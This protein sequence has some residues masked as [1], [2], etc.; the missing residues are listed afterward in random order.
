MAPQKRF[1]SAYTKT[2]KGK[3]IRKRPYYPKTVRGHRHST[4]GKIFPLLHVD[5]PSKLHQIHKYFKQGPGVVLVIFVAD[6][7]GHCQNLKPH[8]EAAAKLPN[9]SIQMMTVSDN[10]VSGYN[11]TVN[12]FNSSASPVEPDGFPSPILVKSNGEKIS[13]I[14][15]TEAALN[16]AAVNVAPVAVEAG[17]SPGSSRLS[18]GTRKPVTPRSGSPEMVVNEIITNEL[19][20]PVSGY[21][22]PKKMNSKKM[23]SFE[24]ITRNYSNDTIIQGEQGEEKGEQG[25][26]VGVSPSIQS[27]TFS[28]SANSS[29]PSSRSITRTIPRS[30]IKGMSEGTE[31]E[32]TQ[33]QVD[34]I[35]S[36]RALPD[37]KPVAQPVSPGVVSDIR[38]PGIGGSI[39]GGGRRGGGLYHI[40]SQS[41]YRLAP[42][43]VLLATAAAVMKKKTRTHKKAYQQKLKKSGTKKRRL[44]TKL[45]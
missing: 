42:A 9:R 17:L 13:E 33:K 26:D 10:M 24:H 6:W 27:L 2:R 35:T 19:S 39:I 1:Q 23:N 16:S 22:I 36:I 21:T 11:K 32:I 25:E 40:M 37:A 38:V 5:R 8:I 45:Y 3:K 44:K 34:E 12:G 15:A 4:A 31:R 14:A 41:A 7:C 20:A 28:A 29:N 30:A 18:N 43:A